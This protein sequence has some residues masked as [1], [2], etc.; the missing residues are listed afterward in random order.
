MTPMYKIQTT[1]LL[2]E[3]MQNYFTGLTDG[4]KIA[5]CSSAGPSELL[6]SFGFNVYFPENHGALLGATRTA[7][8]YFRVRSSTVEK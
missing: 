3:V 1:G 6:R 4:S 5:W 7:G 8:D 2:K